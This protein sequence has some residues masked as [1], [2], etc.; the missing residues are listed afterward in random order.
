MA[1]TKC[2]LCCEAPLRENMDTYRQQ[3]SNSPFQTSNGQETHLRGEKGKTQFTNIQLTDSLHSE[4]TPVYQAGEDLI[5]LNWIRIF[6]ERVSVHT[7]LHFFQCLLDLQCQLAPSQ[8]LDGPSHSLQPKT[9]DLENATFPNDLC[10]QPSLH[11]PKLVQTPHTNN[12]Q[13]GALILTSN[14]KLDG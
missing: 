6:S 13:Q 1:Q 12:R 11:F 3:K 10:I 8:A 14:C 4:F 9:Q 5:I 2:Q 7:V